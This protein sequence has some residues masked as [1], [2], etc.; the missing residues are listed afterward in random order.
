MFP[1]GNLTKNQVRKIACEY[2][3]DYI[4]KK[5]ESRGICFIGSRNFKHFISQV[6]MCPKKLF[7]CVFLVVRFFFFC[8]AQKIEYNKC[9]ISNEEYAAMVPQTFCRCLIIGICFRILY[10]LFIMF[11]AFIGLLYYTLNLQ[12]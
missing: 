5:K 2:E 8:K 6:C 7:Y 3:M 4:V 1:L 9:N 10:L 11:M 12:K